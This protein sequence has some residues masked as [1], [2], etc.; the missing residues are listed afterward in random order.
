MSVVPDPRDIRVVLVGIDEYGGDPRWSL[1]GPVDDAVRFAEFFVAAGVPPEKITVLTTPAPANL[2]AGVV[3][4]PADRAT[5]RDVFVR[6]LSG[7]PENNLVVLW[8]GHGYVDLDRHRRLFYPEAT[9]ADPVDLDLDSLLRRFGTD[10]VSALDRQVWVIDTC[11]VHGPGLGPPVAGHEVFGAGKAVEGRA[12]D[13]YL[14]AGYGRPAFNLD[15]QRTGLFSREVLRLIESHGL[16]LLTDPR[17]LTGA[18]EKRFTEL[19]SSGSFDQTPT[20]LWY[21]DFR[22]RRGSAAAPSPGRLAGR[23]VHAWR[24]AVTGSPEAPGGCSCRRRG[25][26]PA[27]R[28]RGDPLAAEGRDLRCDP[29]QSPRA[30]RRR[31]GDPH[32]LAIPERPA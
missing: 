4:R 6:E 12:Q 29:A 9:A 26:S 16:G 24:T 1:A 32:L 5:V 22:G 30:A 2:P 14:A 13:V 10:E 20:Y 27:G 23:A 25:V 8:G 18:L 17:A 11:Q 3:S 31:R 19:R 21:R 7:S 15:R 28:S